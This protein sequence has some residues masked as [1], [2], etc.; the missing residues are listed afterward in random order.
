MGVKV[1]H[2]AAG[3]RLYTPRE[4]LSPSC[5]DS[6]QTVNGCGA[7]QFDGP[8]RRSRGVRCS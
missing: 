8:W 2:R 3:L 5:D 1:F 4:P 7:A 6:L